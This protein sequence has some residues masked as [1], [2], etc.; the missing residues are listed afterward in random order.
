MAFGKVVPVPGQK[1]H[2]RVG[3]QGMGSVSI[4]TGKSPTPSTVP[5][6]V[7]I[8]SIYYCERETWNS[9][10]GEVLA[11]SQLEVLM[12]PLGRLGSQGQL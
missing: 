11:A 4:P 2:V 6:L 5:E 1:G 9:W 8:S 3:G 7:F 12:H 10:K